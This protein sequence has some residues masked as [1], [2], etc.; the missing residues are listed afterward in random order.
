[1][2]R[3]SRMNKYQLAMQSKIPCPVVLTDINLAEEET[4]WDIF[5]V[6][7]IDKQAIS[8]SLDKNT[9]YDKKTC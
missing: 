9:V 6:I 2:P 5:H 3:Q 7:L 8:L 4:T 1:M